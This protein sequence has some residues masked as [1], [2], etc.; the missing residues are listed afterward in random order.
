MYFLGVLNLKAHHDQLS[1]ETHYIRRVL[2]IP[3]GE[4]PEDEDEDEDELP[5][6]DGILCIIICMTPEA[7][8]RL[9][10]SGRYLQSDIAFRRI[11]GFKEF[12]VAGMERDTNTSEFFDMYFVVCLSNLMSAQ[13]LYIYASLLIG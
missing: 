11:T 5:K 2:L 6:G 7:S 1:K 10:S 12:E 8:R 13:V 3:M 4:Q 9:I